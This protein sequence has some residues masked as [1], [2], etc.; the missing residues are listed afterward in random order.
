M[1]ESIPWNGISG[2][3]GTGLG[4]MVIL[5]FW[6]LMSTGRI[7]P[8]EQVDRMMAAK[9]AQIAYL[10]DA[11]TKRDA[12]NSELTAQVTRLMVQGDVQTRVLQ[13]LPTTTHAGSDH[14]A[15]SE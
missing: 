10:Q 3:I 11:L 9:D 8:A 14:V 4:L 5:A 7:V 15:T 1:L 13:S 2:G 12:A 6:R